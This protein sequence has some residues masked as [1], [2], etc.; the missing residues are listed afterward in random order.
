MTCNGINPVRI[1]LEGNEYIDGQLNTFLKKLYFHCNFP[2]A[3]IEMMNNK[4]LLIES[5]RNFMKMVFEYM[6]LTYE[7]VDCNLLK[8]FRLCFFK[9]YALQ[10]GAF[11]TSCFTKGS[12]DTKE[13]T[14]A[15]NDELTREV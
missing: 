10:C 4:V 13:K 3:K 6:E 2:E 7:H 8:E 12:E 14:R 11:L 5:I 1:D 15:I 9:V